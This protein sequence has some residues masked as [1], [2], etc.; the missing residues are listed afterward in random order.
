M[1]TV[2]CWLRRPWRATSAIVLLLMGASVVM[3]EGAT[4]T[5]ATFASVG[6]GGA[7]SFGPLVKLGLSTDTL[8]FDLRGDA[9]TGSTCVVTSEAGDLIAPGSSFGSQPV[10]PAGTSFAISTFPA[11]E[12]RGGRALGSDEFSLVPSGSSVVCYR[13]FTMAAFSNTDGWQVTVDR[14]DV[15]NTPAIEDLYLAAACKSMEPSGLTRLT[16]DDAVTLVRDQ[17]AGMCGEAVVI[18]AVKLGS[19]SAGTSAVGL[20]YTL[21]SAGHD[22]V[23][24]GGQP[25]RGPR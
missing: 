17:E 13:T 11:V 25:H 20:R 15:P 22:F 5:G 4:S 14:F 2:L 16:G 18:V 7:A 23:P 21:M 10:L 6:L 12:V 1:S 8:V 3:A 24:S 19:G 9:A